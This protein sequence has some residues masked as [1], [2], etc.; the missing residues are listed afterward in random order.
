M[1]QIIKI[2]NFKKKHVLIGSFGNFFDTEF[3][4][5][6]ENSLKS[7]KFKFFEKNKIFDFII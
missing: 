7:Q 2:L 5:L 3:F 6:L 1:R 4:Y